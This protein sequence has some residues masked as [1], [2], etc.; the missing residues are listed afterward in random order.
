M[1]S[2]HQQQQAALSLLA[3]LNELTIKAF[4][5]KNREALV[6][7]ILNETV[8]LIRYDRAFLWGLKGKTPELIGVSGQSSFSKDSEVI[9]TMQALIGDLVNPTQVQVLSADT[10]ATMGEK[11]EALQK[12]GPSGTVLWVPIL[13]E[14]KFALGLWLERW[15][16]VSWHTEE[17]SLL[18]YLARGYAA[19]W[20]KFKSIWQVSDPVK[21]A[22][23]IF[24]V[25]VLLLLGFMPTPLR[26]VAP[27]EVVAKDPIL[28]TAPLNG[29]VEQVVVQPGQ[30]VKN[31]QPLFEY[32]KRVPLQDLKVAEKQVDIAKSQLNRVMTQGY[33][34]PNALNEAAIWQLQ[35]DRDQIKLDLAEYQASQ[36]VVKAPVDGVATFDD[37][38]Q[39][40]GRP[41][42]V[43]E[44]V[45]T[46]VNPEKTKLKIWI[47]ESDNI[48]LLGD[49][50]VN[51]FLNTDPANT[52]SA[53]IIYV[54]DYSLV[55]E[56][57]ITSFVAEAD[58]VRAPDNV[59]IGLK[60]T[61][62]LYGEYVPLVY[63]VLRKPWNT[64]RQ[65]IGL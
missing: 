52:Y 23:K 64:L 50:P 57:G 4:S 18:S 42:Q 31:E 41:V 17:L 34:D 13:I 38:D 11:F 48:A 30:A 49:Q 44:R 39:W 27:C 5:C 61:A 9:K 43:G 8:R 51:I 3:G 6:F 26:V 10:F 60:G 1:T 19:A 25:T 54:A 62:V 59:K 16:Q 53:K 46:V 29:I 14:G 45:M 40:R 56:T 12:A 20:H 33:N 36:L 15:N 58:W 7:L 28:I 37:P 24:G 63:W 21:A 22:Y 55:S 35:L 65:T 32:D 47:S 2:S